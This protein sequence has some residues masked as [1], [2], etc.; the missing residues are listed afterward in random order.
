MDIEN[1]WNWFHGIAHSLSEDRENHKLVQEL[2]RRVLQLHPRLSWEIGPGAVEPW[3]FVISPNLD[4]T[5]RTTAQEIISQAPVIEGWEFYPA[6]RPKRWDY[7][8]LM[9]RSDGRSPVQLDTSGWEFVLLEYPDGS[10][11]ILL[12]GNNV[13]SLEEDNRSLAAA[14]VLESILGEEV[15]MNKISEFELMD[16]IEPRFAASR[17]PIQQLRD[18]VLGA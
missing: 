14:I 16:Q 9:N 15:L 7:K 12:Q 17:K 8:L 18:K 5:L 13:A 11:E 1:F 4:R 3:Q 6:R 10:L 2:D